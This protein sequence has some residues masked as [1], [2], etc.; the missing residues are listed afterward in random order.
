MN[1][2]I[3]ILLLLLI[4]CSNEN[5]A[6]GNLECILRVFIDVNAKKNT[7]GIFISEM[8]NW[9]DSSTLVQIVFLSKGDAID[10]EIYRS[11]YNGIP[12]YLESGSFSH[13]MNQMDNDV[14]KFSISNN[15]K[16]EKVFLSNDNSSL[17]DLWT[18]APEIQIAFSNIKQCIDSVIV[19]DSLLTEQ[20]WD[21]CQFC[22]NVSHSRSGR[23]E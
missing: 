11:F 10:G 22:G 3:Y 20:M 2:K 8:L 6:K 4:S 23:P 17:D 9:T 15:L 18:D 14:K 1:K 13:E 12:V 7:S 19:G 21:K 16:W 5:K